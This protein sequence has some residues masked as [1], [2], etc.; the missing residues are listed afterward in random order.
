MFFPYF[1]KTKQKR[2]WIFD[3]RGMNISN[4]GKDIDTVAKNY[5]IRFREKISIKYVWK[6]TFT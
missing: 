1:V 6:Y 5:F 4:V 3:F 2:S